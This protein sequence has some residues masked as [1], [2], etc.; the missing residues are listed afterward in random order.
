MEQ[1]LNLPATK[2]DI[3]QVMDLLE[4][5]KPAILPGP[6]PSGE[7]DNP[8]FTSIIKRL[9]LIERLTRQALGIGLDD[10]PVN[11]EAASFITGLAVNTL[12]KRGAY[13]RID[14]IKIGKKLQFSLRGCIELVN[15]S[16]RKA[17]LTEA[18]IAAY[19]HSKAVLKN[20]KRKAILT[21]TDMTNYNHTKAVLKNVK[22][23]VILDGV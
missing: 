14:T 20:I 7:P 13:Q 6:G 15:D 18:D 8:V 16:K 23:G 2:E 11:A 1:D 4:S 5:L 21:E 10:I 22:K 3:K 19:N 17:V 12:L 9:D